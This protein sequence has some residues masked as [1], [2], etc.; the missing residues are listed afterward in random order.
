M[1]LELLRPVILWMALKQDQQRPKLVLRKVFLHAFP[2]LSVLGIYAIWRIFVFKFPYYVP[3]LIDANYSLGERISNLIP[4]IT[5][6]VFRA[7]V[8]AWVNPFNPT[9]FD[10]LGRNMLLL[11][12]AVFL[13]GTAVSI[14]LLKAQ[15]DLQSKSPAISTLRTDSWPI[16]SILLGVLALFLAGWPLWIAGLNVKLQPLDNRFTLPF[17]FGSVLLL[18]GLIDLLPG[19]PVIKYGLVSILI[20]LCCSWHLQSTNL[21]RYEWETVKDFYWQLTWRAPGLKPGTALLSNDIPL[22]YYSDNSLTA[23]LNWTYAPG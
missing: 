13:I 3:V 2:Y 10:L 9:E 6:S 8:L 22:Y 17:I 23:M 18:A 16:Q 21:F 15:N 4:L 12:G 11:Y 1:V 20:G 19:K 14:F 7:G 5:D